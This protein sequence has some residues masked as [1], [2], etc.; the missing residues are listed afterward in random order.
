MVLLA[1]T[2]DQSRFWKAPDLAAEKKFKIRDVTEEVVGEGKYKQVK[3]VIWF[4]NDK[5]GL[6]LNKTNNR[7]IRTAFGD[8]TAG[9]AGKIIVMFPT[10]AEFRG[11]M[12]PA[13]R[14][15][16]PPTKSNGGAAAKPVPPVPPVKDTELE[17]DP[18][19]LIANDDF[20][21]EIDF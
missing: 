5:R 6:V 15:R 13:L 1:S 16:I 8:D 10:M 17:V 12:K 3:L 14:V 2:Y 21:D 19:P 7:V 20:D 9:W 11:D 18:T 4:T